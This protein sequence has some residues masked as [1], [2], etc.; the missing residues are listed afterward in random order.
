[1]RGLVELLVEKSGRELLAR[2]DIFT[3]PEEFAARL[4]SPKDALSSPCADGLL[5][6]YVHQQPSPDYSWTVM[7]KFEALSAL[8]RARAVAPCFVVIDTDRAASSKSATRIGWRDSD[9]CPVT[10]KLTPPGSKYHEF[11]HIQTDP[12]QLQDVA[13]RLSSHLQQAPSPGALHR[14]VRLAPLLAP[15]QALAYS[16]YASELAGFLI[17]DCADVAPPQ[18]FVSV[19]QRHSAVVAALGRLLEALDDFIAAFNQ[20]I[21]ALRRLNV[22]T[23]VGLL[24]EDYL[25]F[26]FSCPV[27]GERVR[28]RRR[29]VQGEVIAEAWTRRGRCYRFSLGRGA[30]M[31]ELLASQRFSLDVMLPVVLSNLFSGLVAGQ[32]S[33]LY[34]MVMRAAMKKA[35]GETLCPVLAPAMLAERPKAPLGLLQRWLLEVVR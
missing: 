32:S 9:G 14:F 35:L 21:E 29:K 4:S 17:A 22:A 30:S 18:F 34:C 19:L 1:M 13:R 3:E 25:P 15:Q 27:D 20:Q 6:V 26:F 7:A 33:A 31:D 28:L 8:R 24:P 11:R 10:F 12:A 2:N 5:P 16:R 23:A